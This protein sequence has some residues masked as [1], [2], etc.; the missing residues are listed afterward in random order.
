MGASF[1]PT[2]IVV[3]P[4]LCSRLALLTLSSVAILYCLG[5]G[6]GGG[7]SGGQVLRATGFFNQTGLTASY[8]P[9]TGN[10][11]SL[12]STI[13]IPGAGS[14]SGFIGLENLQGTA[15]ILTSTAYLSYAISGS[16]F[17]V[18]NDV[19]P[20]S[21]NVPPSG[22]P[23]LTQVFAQLQLLSAARMDF[24]RS[25]SGALPP[26]PFEMTITVTV[27]GQSPAGDTFSSN[28]VTYNVTFTN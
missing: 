4:F 19:F 2:K 1:R 3:T 27:E 16:S 26:L 20:F 21:M 11:V 7:S 13:S 10:A 28:P 15:P 14:N 18:P 17:L 9:A 22:G 24:L 23:S 6:Q 5:C 8:T 25:N 12:S